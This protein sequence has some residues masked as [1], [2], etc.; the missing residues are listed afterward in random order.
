MYNT[1]SFIGADEL[2]IDDQVLH[3]Q[4]LKII[5]MGFQ[6]AEKLKFYNLLK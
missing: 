1:N 6:T 2:M 4:S 5:S 3:H